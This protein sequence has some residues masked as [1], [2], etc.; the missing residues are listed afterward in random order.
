MLGSDTLTNEANARISKKKKT[1][2][3]LIFLRGAASSRYFSIVLSLTSVFL[4]RPFVLRWLS[5][6]QHNFS[7]WAEN[8]LGYKLRNPSNMERNFVALVRPL[9][10]SVGVSSFWIIHWLCFSNL[11]PNK[12]GLNDE[13]I[14]DL[15]I[16]RDKR[17]ICDVTFEKTLSYFGLRRWHV[18][19]LKQTPAV[20]K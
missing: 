10:D 12:V 17:R 8:S 11:W 6:S 9:A 20:G 18:I 3:H 14:R 5:A 2:K 4:L 13:L 16:W 19:W 15:S 7:L 1:Q